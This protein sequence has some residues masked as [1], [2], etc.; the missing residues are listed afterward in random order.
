MFQ[1]NAKTLFFSIEETSKDILIETIFY[2]TLI[3]LFFSIIVIIAILKYR[4]K[5]REFQE[6]EDTI[7]NELIKASLE[8][9]EQTMEEL[10]ARLH[11]KLQQTLSLA[12]LNLNTM[13]MRPSNIDIN[14]IESTKLLIT[15]SIKE[16]KDLSKDLDPKYI[17]GYTLEENIAQQL[18]RVEDKTSIKTH[19]TTSKEEINLKKNTQIFTYRIIQEA[20]NNS[21]NHADASLIAIKLVN[22]PKDFDVYVE[23]NGKGFDTSILNGESNKAKGIGLLSIQNRTQLMNGTFTIKSQPNNGTKINLNIPL[24]ESHGD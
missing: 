19:F 5:Q 23:D 15:E 24:N 18:Q 20:I 22:N 3:L 14:K 1:Q 16:I 17:T 6:R 12:K 10:A 11:I 13:L 9:K 4:N 7:K 2:S 8:S 21:L